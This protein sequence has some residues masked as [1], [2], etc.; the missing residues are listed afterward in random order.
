[1]SKNETGLEDDVICPHCKIKGRGLIIRDYTRMHDR[2]VL[3]ECGSCG[4]L[5]KVYYVFDKI[6][7]LTEHID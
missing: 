4:K 3:V 2:E 5:Y 7:K 1:M 6:V